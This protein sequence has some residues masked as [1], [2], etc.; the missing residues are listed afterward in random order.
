MT[1]TERNVWRFWLPR[2]ALL[3]VAIANNPMIAQG[4]AQL[5]IAA[6]QVA[7]TAAAVDRI[8]NA[9]QSGGVPTLAPP[10]RPFTHPLP[11]GAS[12]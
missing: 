12:P 10:R 8:H 5:G 6:H 4:Q 1:N 2:L 11:S 9:W 7:G 3:A